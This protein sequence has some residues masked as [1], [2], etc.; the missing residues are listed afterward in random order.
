[1]H[2]D[3]KHHLTGAGAHI[4]NDRITD[5]GDPAEELQA[6]A[7]GTIICDLSHFGVMRFA[8]EDAQT[9]LQG[10]LSNDVKHATASL[11]Q[12][13]SYCTPKGRMLANMLLWRDDEGFNLQLPVEVLAGV[14]K[15]LAMYILRAKV[16]A[17]DDSDASV[18]VGLNGTAAEQLLGQLGEIPGALL[19]VAQFPGGRIIRL[20]QERF[21]LMLEPGQ[22]IEIWQRLAEGAKPVGAQCWQ[23]LEIRAG[24]PT[25]LAKTQEAFVPQ[26]V[27]FELI[28]GVNFK[29]GCYPGQEIVARTHY[30]G[31]LKRRMYQA[32]V[33]TLEAPA[34]GDSVYS[35]ELTDQASGEVVVSA[36]SPS[37]GFDLL[38][39]VQISS[40]AG[41]DVHLLRADGPKLE[42]L[43]LPYTFDA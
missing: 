23:W 36:P 30:L 24:V 22:G 34:P 43:P 9:F 12:Y 15:R 26:M 4:K 21:E 6:C 1:M 11:G 16:Q 42:F 35:S 13:T 2:A 41:G 32:H 39:V 37:G 14:L 29:K 33:D 27:N 5:F 25:V 31:K 10:Q 28:G 7:S 18:R 8:G 19:G 3:W 17:R 20:G 38:A 40:A